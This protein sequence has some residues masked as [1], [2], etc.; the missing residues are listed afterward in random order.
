MSS[1]VR[2]LQTGLLQ[3]LLAGRQ[4]FDME[5]LRQRVVV[6]HITM[7]ETALSSL[8]T[9][10]VL[11]SEVQVAPMVVR[12][13]VLVASILVLLPVRAATCTSA[14]QDCP[15]IFAEVFS[16]NTLSNPCLLLVLILVQ[17]ILKM[18]ASSLRCI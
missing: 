1:L 6:T 8:F 10:C 13:N 18:K 15:L 17:M 7:L 5:Y 4:L 14:A 3:D 16:D 9:T 11:N 12:L 2:L